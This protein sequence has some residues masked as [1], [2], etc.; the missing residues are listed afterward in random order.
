[1]IG[2]AI[3][4]LVM[5]SDPSIEADTPSK[6][7]LRRG[8]VIELVMEKMAD[9]G[10]CLAYHNGQ[11]VFVPHT[12]AG[13]H[14]RA[15]VVK[16]RRK[17][18]EAQLLAVLQPSPNRVQPRCGYFGSCGGCTLQTTSYTRQLEDKY[19]L[20]R[21]AMTRIADLPNLEI[22]RP[23]KSTA[24]Y[25]YRNKME[26]SFSPYRWLT[27]EEID[28]GEVFDT[29]FAL[30]LH[31][32]NVFAKILDIHQCH[33]QDERSTA[34]VNGIRVLAKQHHWSPWNWRNKEGFL[35][36]L[37]IRQS[38][39]M[40]DFMVN[41]I[42][43][44]YDT[45]RMSRLQAYFKE[46]HPYVTTLVNTINSTPAQTA[47]GERTETIYGPGILRE[48]I[49]EL[50]FEIAPGAFFQT[51]TLQAEQLV[52]VVRDLAGVTEKDHVYD[53]YCGTGTI[54]LSLAKHAAH[55]TGIELI[56][57]AIL[58]ARSNAALNGIKNATFISGDML[59]LLKPDLITEHGNPDVVVLDPPRAGMH[60][61]VAVQVSR[62]NARRI[63]YVSCNIQSQARDLPIL[64]KSYDA[65]VA[66]PVDLFPQTHHLENV[67]LLEKKVP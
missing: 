2:W 38:V 56:E 6:P 3:F 14:V 25:G 1:M 15:K 36:H 59:R 16:R 13:E 28:S 12:L 64:S 9:R 58:N 46:E 55:V 41:L 19:Q 21:E 33:L 50:T 43:S 49:G 32:P 7:P 60:P 47:F 51:N 54:A 39:H 48:R 5:P 23:L 18:A 8:D 24:I 52:N 57:D 61:K 26:F 29:S 40:S 63:V 44:E 34:V 45:E 62:L 42:T 10:K 35:R 67:V 22:R 31:P 30:G 65:V 17:F 37:V 11:V 27:R 20:V 66:Q 53:L 4:A